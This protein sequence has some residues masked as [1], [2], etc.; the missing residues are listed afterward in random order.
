MSII[1][2]ERLT[3]RYGAAL[4]L[5][6]VSL[7]IARDDRI[8]L[9][10]PNGSG[11]STLLKALAG[12]E[13]VND[14]RIHRARSLR[15]GYL[16]QEP[17]LA[18]EKTLFEAMLEAKREVLDIEQQLRALERELAERP[19]DEQLLHR[20]DELL[21]R[22]SAL[23]GYEYQSAIHRVLAGL[24]FSPE[25]ER[26]PLRQLSGG[27]RARAA[28]ARL[29][30]SEPD[31]LLLDEPTNHLDLQALE[32][33]EEHLQ[34]WKG[35]YVIA[36]HDRYLI[37]KLARRIWE[38]EDGKLT[39]YPGNYT[40]YL[41]LKRAK[42]ERQR[43]LYEEQQKL[44]EKTEE[45]IR[46]NIA[47]GHFRSRQAQS[48]R[49][50]LERLK[51]EQ[52][53]LPK[54][55]KALHFSIPVER[56]SGREVLKIHQLVV[57]YPDRE[58]FRFED[59]VLV[60]R[61]ERVALIGPNGCGKTTL[62]RTL[63]G[64]LSPLDG[65]FELGHH[66]QLVYHRQI[67]WEALDPNKTV[68]ETLMAGRHQTISEAR[69]FL[70][71]FLFSDDDV[72]KKIG[73]LSGGERSRVALAQLAQLG[74]NVLLLDEP[75]NHLDITSREALQDALQRYEGTILFVSHDR[76]L[77]QALATQI[78]EVQ[79]SRCRIYQGT[80]QRYLERRA[81]ETQAPRRGAQAERKAQPTR[82]P[83]AP[84]SRARE[85]LEVS[86]VQQR[87]ELEARE[88]K[89]SQALI[90]LEEQIA[91]L[92]RALQEASYAGDPER[93]RLLTR[94]YQERKAALEALY[95]EWNAVVDELQKLP[96]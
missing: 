74:G 80:Y 41:Q 7:Q 18:S 88:A 33:L 34:N 65:R 11:K 59:E 87:K 67:Q 42:I 68:L 24:G 78:W 91:Q 27:Q 6:D 36:S 72:F 39:E 35:G 94:E 9:I 10:G 90:E 45:F 14:G 15:L 66:V 30:L 23:G 86:G 61:G 48:R 64:E 85:R 26:R 56:P 75:T 21:E 51:R 44:I 28:L 49:K 25:D 3:K 57:G 38:L 22:Y 52:V 89:L 54:V 37:D 46:R 47:G 70:G 79:D 96:A 84:R 55:S 76:Y 62:L 5:R 83:K 50:L 17:D 69:D 93:I 40:K 95:Q 8:A 1:T 29:L 13:E 71:Q 81:E 43:K 82:Q 92:E 53:E 20:Y 32:W 12:L 19:D 58:L 77:I 16:P 31:L 73:E 60:Q 63:A 2:A 4:V